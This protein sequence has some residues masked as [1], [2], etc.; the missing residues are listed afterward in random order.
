MWGLDIEFEA[1]LLTFRRAESVSSCPAPTGESNPTASGH[2]EAGHRP[3][4][5]YSNGRVCVQV[6]SWHVMGV[7]RRVPRRFTCLGSM[8]GWCTTCSRRAAP[9]ARRVGQQQRLWSRP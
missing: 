1:A 2:R 4:E 3:W 6:R 8:I 5:E 7:C 9:H